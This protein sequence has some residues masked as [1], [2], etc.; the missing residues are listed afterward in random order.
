MQVMPRLVKLE[1]QVAE[2]TQSAF[3][4][5]FEAMGGSGTMGRWYAAEPRLVGADFIHPMP[6][7]AKIVGGLLY[8][9]LLDGY[10]QF[11]LKQMKL[12]LAAAGAAETRGPQPSGA[13]NKAR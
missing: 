4:N 8:E 12:K 5:T 9:G 6:A 7:G 11:K 10:N 3:F 1:Q 13:E 2:A